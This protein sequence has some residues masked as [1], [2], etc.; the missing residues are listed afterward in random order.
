MREKE[1][2]RKF[3]NI[4]FLLKHTGVHR[5]ELKAGSRFT[6]PRGV[7]IGGGL[8]WSSGV[9]AGTLSLMPLLSVSWLF[10]ELPQ[11]SALGMEIYSY[12]E[13]TLQKT[14]WKLA[15]ANYMRQE[16][17]RPAFDSRNLRINACLDTEYTFKINVY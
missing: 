14:F 9:C 6:S 10:C 15:E 1:W 17:S 11:W 4:N 12:K 7:S 2:M 8:S 3:E 13:K 16:K 5:D